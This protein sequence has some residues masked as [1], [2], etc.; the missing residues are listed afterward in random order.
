MRASSFGRPAAAAAVLPF[1]A[2]A[3]AKAACVLEKLFFMS[4]ANY[5]NELPPCD[6]ALGAISRE[7]AE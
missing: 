2:L 7:F 4:G 5:S 1:G 3:P 6:A